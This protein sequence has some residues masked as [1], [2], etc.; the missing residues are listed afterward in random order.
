MNVGNGVKVAIGV[1]VG[2][3]VAVFVGLAVGVDVLPVATLT[4]V[5]N[6]VGLCKS[7]KLGSCQG[8]GPQGKYGS[9]SCAWAIPA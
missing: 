2:S 8:S 3:A 6:G 1:D 9:Q 7:G 4:I 5:G